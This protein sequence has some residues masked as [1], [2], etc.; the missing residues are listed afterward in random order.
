MSVPPAENTPNTLSR[1]TLAK[2][3]AWSTPVIM[4]SALAPAYAVSGP[5]RGCY[6]YSFSRFAVGTDANGLTGTAN[7][8]GNAPSTTV[9]TRVVRGGTA[10]AVDPRTVGLSTGKYSS[11]FNGKI[12]YRGEQIGYPA[13]TSPYPISGLTQASP[14][15]V[16]NIGYNTTTR[17]TFEFPVPL[18]SAS[19]TILDITRS[20]SSLSSGAYRYA[21]TVTI[22]QPW[23]MTGDLT[24]A[25]A[26]S[27]AAG[28]TFSRSRE[29]ASSQTK[30]VRNVMSTKTTSRF[31]SLTFTYTAPVSGGWEFLAIPS[32]SFCVA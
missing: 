9:T 23:V 5:V 28:V 3:I 26:T 32:I 21:D 19:I 16:L 2:G 4:A 6:D 22:D 14:G 29:Y 13:S 1:R 17:V 24:S 11:K 7:S 25:N 12:D 20:N 18:T 15:L 27:G 8:Q 30:T 10:G 31:S